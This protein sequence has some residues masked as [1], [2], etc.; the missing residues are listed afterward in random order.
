[1]QSAVVDDVPHPFE[2]YDENPAASFQNDSKSVIVESLPTD[3]SAGLSS[4]EEHD[5]IDVAEEKDNCGP[6]EDEVHEDSGVEEEDGNDDDGSEE[7][8]EEEEEEAAED[9]NVEEEE[10]KEEE[11]EDDIEEERQE[12][13]FTLGSVLSPLKNDSTPIRCV[14]MLKELGSPFHKNAVPVQ[15]GDHATVEHELE[16]TSQSRHAFTVEETR[17]ERTFSKFIRMTAMTVILVFIIYSTLAFDSSFAFFHDVGANNFGFSRAVQDAEIQL[18]ANFE[19]PSEQCPAHTGDM[20][21]DTV[22]ITQSNVRSA[23]SFESAFSSPSV[24]TLQD[25]VETGPNILPS[26]ATSIASG[27]KSTTKISRSTGRNQSHFAKQKWLEDSCYRVLGSD[28]NTEVCFSLTEMDFVER[29]I[30]KVSLPAAAQQQ[31]STVHDAAK[32]TPRASGHAASMIGCAGFS[33]VAAYA[34]CRLLLQRLRRPTA[35]QTDQV[36]PEDVPTPTLEPSEFVE[37]DMSGP[38]L[39]VEP[40]LPGEP[41]VPVQ[42]TPTTANYADVQAMGSYSGVRCTKNV[43]T[44]ATKV[45]PVRR[46]RRIAVAKKDSFD[47]VIEEGDAAAIVHSMASPDVHVR[48][49]ARLSRTRDRD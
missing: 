25:S 43:S 31:L 14:N 21:G 24:P 7:E 26:S 44:G 15:D 22:T 10:E 30:P 2:V 17:V 8:E 6:K 38:Q 1:M 49:S 39:W 32:S 20:S 3:Q 28:S 13:T 27:T 23:R 47:F 19:W 29:E 16:E 41:P 35:V 40:A 33:A 48:R 9:N 11:E 18:V 4:K 5:D 36:Q 45:T 46:S 12:S 42:L 34:A 37:S